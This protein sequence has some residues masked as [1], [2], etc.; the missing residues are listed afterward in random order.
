MNV[1]SSSNYREILKETVEE[2]KR[3]DRSYTFQRLA[4]EIHVQKPYLSKVLK[5]DAHLSTDQ[6][7]MAAR[8]LGLTEEETHY[9]DL[10]L[11]LAR[12]GL[13]DRRKKLQ[14]AVSAIQEANL[15]SEKSLANRPVLATEEGIIEY[16]LQP[17]HQVV[18]ICLSIDR[19]RANPTLL[20]TELGLHPQMLLP[21]L[22]NL[23]RMGLVKREGEKMRVQVRNIH[24]PRDSAAYVAW[25]NQVRLLALQRLQALP[26]EK[27]YGFS[28]AFSANQE[29]YKKVQSRFLEFLRE[30]DPWIE[31]A[32][33]EQA[34]QV[35]FDL[36][37]WTET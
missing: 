2:R 11:E 36:F 26:R 18:H 24:L 25:R 9:L 30:I 6:L 35:N 14:K 7:F 8:A 32:P 19:Y 10:L 20:A 12:T 29:T 37:P 16:Y 4:E 5:G 34:F 31:K 33:P 23:E 17:I 21:V 3:I 27:A 28:M 22:D 1:F 15:K 13:P